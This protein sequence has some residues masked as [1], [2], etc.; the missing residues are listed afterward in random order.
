LALIGV[1]TQIVDVE[2]VVARELIPVWGDESL[3]PYSEACSSG[4]ATESEARYPYTSSW[5]KDR[6]W[7]ILGEGID[8]TGKAGANSGNAIES[9]EGDPA[10]TGI[11]LF[12][13]FSGGEDAPE[14]ASRCKRGTLTREEN[15]AGNAELKVRC[16]FEGKFLSMNPWLVIERPARRSNDG[17]ISL[18][19]LCAG[20]TPQEQLRTN[21]T[22]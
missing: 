5:V 9:I 4:E 18:D 21:W 7:L 15:G 11:I 17:V 12:I 16:G 3:C 2:V 13:S 1:P 20:K 8:I 10:V 19:K 22:E 14:K 6:K